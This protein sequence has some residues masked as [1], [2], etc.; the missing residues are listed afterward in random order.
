MEIV[1]IYYRF[2]D[3]IANSIDHSM[4]F[5]IFPQCIGKYSSSRTVYSFKQVVDLVKNNVSA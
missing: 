1:W 4:N 3:A 2:S 5:T